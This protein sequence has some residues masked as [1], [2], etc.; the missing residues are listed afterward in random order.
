MFWEELAACP[1]PDDICRDNE[2]IEWADSEFDFNI[3]GHITPI[4]TVNLSDYINNPSNLS[5]EYT[6]YHNNQELDGYLLDVV[7]INQTT[8]ILTI[9]LTGDQEFQNEYIEVEVKTYDCIFEAR[10][11]D[12]LYDI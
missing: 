7:Y 6:I 4:T 8:G 3:E 9:N 12:V 2:A 1:V 10:G 5:L 11:E